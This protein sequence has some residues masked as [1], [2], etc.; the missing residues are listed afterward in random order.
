[1]EPSTPPFK[2]SFLG[3]YGKLEYIKTFY[4]DRYDQ[5]SP[6]NLAKEEFVKSGYEGK[7]CFFKIKG[8]T[9]AMVLGYRTGTYGC[10]M[11]LGY[12]GIS[13]SLLVNGAWSDHTIS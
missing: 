13:Y 7:F 2:M 12:N 10:L 3:E 11:A 4:I 6:L 5:G 9:N 1:M 8:N